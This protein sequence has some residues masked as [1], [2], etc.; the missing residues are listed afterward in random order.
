MLN[1]INAWNE[2]CEKGKDN[3]FQKNPPTIQKPHIGKL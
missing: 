2:F 1:K 3:N